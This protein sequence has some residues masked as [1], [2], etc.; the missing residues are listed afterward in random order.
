[1]GGG[2]ETGVRRLTD[3]EKKATI[4]AL[5]SCTPG[6]MEKDGRGWGMHGSP[7]RKADEKKLV[8]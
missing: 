1:V 4:L 8:L 7:R 3:K 2:E 6:K 5:S